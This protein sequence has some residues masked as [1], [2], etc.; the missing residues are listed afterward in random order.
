MKTENITTATAY[1]TSVSSCIYGFIKEIDWLTL[2]SFIVSLLVALTNFYF[3]RKKAILE[4]KKIEAEIAQKQE[5]AR[6]SADF[7]AK[8]REIELK[9]LERFLK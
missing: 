1:C 5:E 3:Q 8:K 9:R 6:L 2:L 7:L 4:I